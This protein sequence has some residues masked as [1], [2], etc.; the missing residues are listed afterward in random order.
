MTKRVASE[1]AISPLWLA[2]I[3]GFIGLAWLLLQ[4]KEIVI[5]LVVGYTIAYVINPVISNLEKRGIPRGLGLLA[6]AT[7][8]VL[9]LVVLALTALP[10][11]SRELRLLI[12]NF[13]GYLET[14]RSNVNQ[15]LEGQAGGILGSLQQLWQNS[16]DDLIS[17][18]DGDFF[19][20]VG[21]G[22]LKAL[23][24]GYSVTLT[25]INVLLL[26]FI[27]YYFAVGFSDMHRWALRLFPPEWQV[28]VRKIALEIDGCLSAFIHG[29]ALIGSLLSAFYAI[30]FGIIG[31]ELW[32]L[33]ALI[34]GFGDLI[35]YFG[36]AIGLVLTSVMTLVT[37]GDWE[38]LLMV[39]GVFLVAQLLVGFYL[40]P[41]VLGKK[42]GLSPLVVIV[43]LLA[44]GKLFGL[45]GIFLAV[46]IAAV[47][48]VLLHSSHA[49]LLERSR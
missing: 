44:G 25:L 19:K 28:K 2:A 18:I 31:V 37:F 7:G 34:S 17:L 43:A 49:W 45:L 33:L 20:S 4:L 9:V 23:L 35:P 32:F 10:T 48:R 6:V 36:L 14:A 30:F 46:P 3:L 21:A 16:L 27:V 39:W 29:Q 12:D 38:H 40:A 8:L 22:L 26:P 47:L 41:K 1:N 5:L 24:K 15:W 42:V 13:P 11:L